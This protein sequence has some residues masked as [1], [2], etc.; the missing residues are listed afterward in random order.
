MDMEINR[1][2]HGLEE[3]RLIALGRTALVE[4]FAL[5]GFETYADATPEALESVLMDL[6]RKQEKALIVLEQSLAR[7]GATMLARVRGESGRIVLVEI[8]P[9]NAPEDHHSAVDELVRRV[10]GTSDLEEW[11]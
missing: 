3:T 6:V 11:P 9:L 5:I 8:P 4:G 7:N 2:D 10:L 1:E